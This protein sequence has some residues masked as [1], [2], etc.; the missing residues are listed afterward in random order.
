MQSFNVQPWCWS[1]KNLLNSSG[2]WKLGN[3]YIQHFEPARDTYRQLGQLTLAWGDMVFENQ[4]DKL[5]P[6]YWEA[7]LQTFGGLN[8]QSF[9]DDYTRLKSWLLFSLGGGDPVTKKIFN[10]LWESS[11]KKTFMA[12]LCNVLCQDEEREFS[13]WGGRLKWGWGGE[14]GERVQ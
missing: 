11:L 8:S 1:S 7:L 12:P 4:A 6:S 2:R 10:G 5:I 13:I 3:S 14:E 9:N